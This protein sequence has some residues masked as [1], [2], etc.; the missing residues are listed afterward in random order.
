MAAFTLSIGYRNTSSWSLRGWLMAR[1]AGIDFAEQFIPY[2]TEEGKALLRAL[3]PSGKVPLLVDQRG[4]APLLV[5]DSL[6]IGEYLAECFP[7]KE[8]WPNGREARALARS[9]SAEMHSGFANLREK[10]P[11]DFLGRDLA[12]PLDDPLLKV[13]LARVSSIWAKCRNR[14]GKDLGGPFLFGTFTLADAMYAPVVSRFRSYGVKLDPICRDYLD[15]ILSDADF[16]AWEAAAV[17][18]AKNLAS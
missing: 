18:E 17:Q 16:L 10:L 5:W 1:K 12:A 2:R 7:Q 6:A 14:F 13:D 8:L 9:V 15:A 3:S 11:M 4:K